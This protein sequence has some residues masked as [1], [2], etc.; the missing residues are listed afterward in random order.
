MKRQDVFENIVDRVLLLGSQST[1]APDEPPGRD[2]PHLLDLER[3]RDVQSGPRIRMGKNMHR[4]ASDLRCSWHYD[5]H[6]EFGVMQRIIADD[7][8]RAYERLLRIGRVDSKVGQPHVTSATGGLSPHADRL[9]QSH[10]A[11][12]SRLGI[13]QALRGSLRQAPR[14]HRSTTDLV[15]CAAPHRSPPRARSSRV[16]RRAWRFHPGVPPGDVKLSSV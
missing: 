11:D 6:V 2:R 14:A 7:E 9:T 15:A 5:D 13:R 10:R 8:S 4:Q 1:K 3:R 12:R 16:A